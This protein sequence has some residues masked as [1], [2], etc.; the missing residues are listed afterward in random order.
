MASLVQAGLQRALLHAP[1]APVLVSCR[2]CLRQQPAKQLL[3]AAT[4]MFSAQTRARARRAAVPSLLA[5]CRQSDYARVAS[6]RGVATGPA[7]PA[8]GAGTGSGSGTGTGVRSASSVTAAAATATA[9]A[10]S[11]AASSS[12]KTSSFPDTSSKAVAYW[13]IGSAI[14]VFGIVVWGGLTRLTESGLSIT[15]WKPVTGSL[16]PRDAA[17]WEAE[18]AKYPPRLNPHMTLAE[19]QQIYFMEWSHRLWGRLVGLTFVVP[20]V[21]FVARRRVTARLAGHLVGIAGLI[22]LQGFIGWWMV[23]SGLRAELF[24]RDAYPPRVSQYRLAT[25]LAAAFACYGWMLLA[26]LGAA[27]GIST[28]IYMVPTHLA[29]THQAGSLALL[30]GVL[31]LGHRLRMPRASL[32]LI[33]KYLAKMPAQPQQAAAAAQ[34][35]AP[36]VLTKV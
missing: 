3:W 30:T 14:S 9:D 21:Y 17:A 35:A 8:A 31:V 28:L 5:Q 19:F 15:E 1:G 32:R 18:F 33:E 24:A 13:L 23:R 16:P 4:A 2:S 34:K 12:S 25:H 20:A 6:R 26:G 29:A 36:R 7:K 10:T 27:L 11:A 22:G